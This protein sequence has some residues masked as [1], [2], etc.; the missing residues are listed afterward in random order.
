MKRQ[1]DVLL[2]AAGSAYSLAQV[3]NWLVTYGPA[4]LTMVYVGLKI[5]FK[6]KH[7]W[8]GRRRRREWD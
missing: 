1:L 5:Y 4:V 3:G 8:K 7:E 6:V 2:A